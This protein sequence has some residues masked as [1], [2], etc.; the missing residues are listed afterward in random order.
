MEQTASHE[1][2]AIDRCRTAVHSCFHSDAVLEESRLQV[3]RI[4]AAGR[5]DMW[6]RHGS[7]VALETASSPA[8]MRLRACKA[9]MADQEVA[10]FEVARPHQ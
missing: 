6:A 8:C 1:S 9:E 4:I 2:A 3:G 7:A 10:G 5:Q